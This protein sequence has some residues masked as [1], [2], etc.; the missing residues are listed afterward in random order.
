MVQRHLRSDKIVLAR[1]ARDRNRLRAR[2]AYYAL[3]VIAHSC[4]EIA[5]GGVGE[6][7]TRVEPRRWIDRRVLTEAGLRIHERADNQAPGFFGRD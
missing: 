3:N 4:G 2:G 6:A 1:T 7:P 5:R